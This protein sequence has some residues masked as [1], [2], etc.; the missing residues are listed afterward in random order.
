[1][2]KKTYERITEIRDTAAGIGSGDVVWVGGTEGAAA[3]F[4][5][6]LTERRNELKDVT[7]LVLTGGEPNASLETLRHC[8][9]FRVLSFYRDALTETYKDGDRREFFVSPA[10]KAIGLICK[11]YNVNTMVV[12][13]C[14]PKADGS[15][16]VDAKQV[17]TALAVS[18]CPSVTKRIALVDYRMKPSKDSFQLDSFDTIG[19]Y[20]DFRTRDIF[21]NIGTAERKA[22]AAA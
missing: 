14:Q 16:A 8:G 1:M 11:H 13:V 15:C 6:A 18:A 17:L 19:L 12:P 22:E 20:G 9:G 7:L 4:L 21:D 10:V 2:M 5:S 3:E